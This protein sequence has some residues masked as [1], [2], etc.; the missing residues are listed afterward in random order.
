MQF[1]FVRFLFKKEFRRRKISLFFSFETFCIEYIFVLLQNTLILTRYSWKKFWHWLFFHTVWLSVNL[2]KS[3]VTPYD[4]FCCGST[5]VSLH[6]AKGRPVHA[7]F[8]I[9]SA[10]TEMCSASW[11]RWSFFTVVVFG[12]FSFNS[13]LSG[14]WYAIAKSTVALIFLLFIFS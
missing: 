3:T 12:V 6:T 14:R 2:R 9:F 7:V 5:I 10:S 4:F 8:I 1:D 11:Y 13:R